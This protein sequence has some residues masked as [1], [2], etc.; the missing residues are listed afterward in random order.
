MGYSTG[1]LDPF[2]KYTNR[3]DSRIRERS[4]LYTQIGQLQNDINRL[5][6]DLPPKESYYATNKPLRLNE[7]NKKKGEI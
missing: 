2:V 3:R 6:K 1:D 5:N 4:K 7:I